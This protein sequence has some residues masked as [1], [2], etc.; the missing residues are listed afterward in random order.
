MSA[1]AAD[2]VASGYWQSFNVQL[3]DPTGVAWISDVTGR[4]TDLISG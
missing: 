2:E 1:A 3:E 4:K